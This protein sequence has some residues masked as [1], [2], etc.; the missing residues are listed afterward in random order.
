MISKGVRRNRCWK[1]A[2]LERDVALAL[3]NGVQWQDLGSHCKLFLLGSNDSPASASRIAGIIGMRH[4]A[5]LIFVFLIE[6]GFHH[7]GQASLELLTLLECSAGISAHYNF[8]LPGS[9]DS[10]ASAS[11]VSGTTGIHHHTQLIFVF[12]VETGFLHVGQAGLELLVSSDPPTSAS[13][14][15]IPGRGATRVAS[16]TLLASAA[17]LLVPGAALPTADYTGRSGSA[18]PIPTRKTA[19]GSAE[20]REFHSKHSEPG[21]VRLCGE[22]ASAKGKLRNRKTSSPGGERSKMAA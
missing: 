10:P 22:G 8:C 6:I 11:R 20:D 7:I 16:A 21:K 17:V 18:G 9:S 12:L 19:I 13:Q 4:H 2:K 5:W 3:Q 15:Q 1:V 14:N